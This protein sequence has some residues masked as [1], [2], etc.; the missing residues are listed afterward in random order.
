MKFSLTIL[1]LAMMNRMFSFHWFN[2]IRMPSLQLQS[3]TNRTMKRKSSILI[4]LSSLTKWGNRM[5]VEHLRRKAKIV[6]YSRLL[7]SRTEE[8]APVK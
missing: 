4:L 6:S 2:K 1:K 3:Q 5:K 7:S 8:I